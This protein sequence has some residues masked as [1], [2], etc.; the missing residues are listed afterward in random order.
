MSEEDDETR[1]GA[2]AMQRNMDFIV[3]QQ[4]QFASD[5]Q[6]LRETQARAE[7]RWS[8]TAEGIRS[9]LSIAEIHEREI[10][11]L[12]ETTR[13]L[14]ETTRSLSETTRSLSEAGRDTDEHGRALSQREA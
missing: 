4:A 11:A 7:E 12:G 1:S 5:M 14:S 6:S 8:S 9:L 2:E 3:R 10:N 13:S